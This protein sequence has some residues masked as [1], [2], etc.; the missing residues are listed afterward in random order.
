MF[1]RNLSVAGDVA[2]SYVLDLLVKRRSHGPESTRSKSTHNRTI[3]IARGFIRRSRYFETH[4][5]REHDLDAFTA[6]DLHRRGTTRPDFSSHLGATCN[7]LDR[8]SSAPLKLNRTA[9]RIRRRTPRS[10]SDR[11]AIVARSSRYCGSSIVES[12]PRCTPHDSKECGFLFE[13]K[14]K[15]IMARSLCLL[16]AKLERICHGVEAMKLLKG[17]APTTPSNCSHDRINQP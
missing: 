11:T 6:S 8:R 4:G 17:S 1:P 14:L 13:A 15:A 12:R 5:I 2:A 9:W 3:F 7:A 16:E 10:R